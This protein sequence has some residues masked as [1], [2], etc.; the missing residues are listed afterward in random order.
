MLDMPSYA[1]GLAM[2]VAFAAVTCLHIPATVKQLCRVAGVLLANWLAGMAFFALS[3]DYSA[4]YFNIFIDAAAAFVVLWKPVGKAQ[5]YIGLFYFIQLAGH[6]A[7][8]SRILLGYPANAAY[9]YDAI[10]IVAWLQL[11]AV[12][13]W[14]G[15]L[16]LQA[17]LHHLRHRGHALDRGSLARDDGP[18]P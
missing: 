12:W 15:G 11:L 2:T 8:G 6:I 3:N 18:T 9:Y 7:Y 17:L 1:L 10:T 4:W 13:G 14:A 16:W 5:Q